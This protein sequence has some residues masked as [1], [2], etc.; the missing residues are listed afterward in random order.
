MMKWSN[1]ELLIFLILLI[2]KIATQIGRPKMK[3]TRLFKFVEIRSTFCAAALPIIRS[4][5]GNFPPT[6]KVLSSQYCLII[7]YFQGSLTPVDMSNCINDKS[8]TKCIFTVFCYYNCRTVELHR[9]KERKTLA[10]DLEVCK[11]RVLSTHQT[12]LN[13]KD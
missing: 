3:L 13:S 2:I 12:S 1:T 5:L 6:W 7:K 10:R 11:S 8:H 4:M 9:W